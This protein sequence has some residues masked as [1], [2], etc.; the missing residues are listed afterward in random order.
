MYINLFIIILLLNLINIIKCFN[1][2][3]L[4]L[5]SNKYYIGK[6]TG[7]I[8]SKFLLHQIGEG[9]DW[10]KTYI[11]KKII[12]KIKSTE[13]LDENIITKKY[14]FKY[15]INNV[16]GGS[17]SNFILNDLEIKYLENEIEK[18]KIEK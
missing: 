13:N 14:M 17:Y 12:K 11:P 16:R 10:T 8:E 7:S 1:I 9:N 2:Y 4:E 6:T 18:L 3:V 15:G 5:A